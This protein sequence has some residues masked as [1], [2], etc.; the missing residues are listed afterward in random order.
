MAAGGMSR[1]NQLR[2]WDSQREHAAAIGGAVFPTVIFHPIASK[3][4]TTSLTT[5]GQHRAALHL[6]GR[7]VE[8]TLLRG[9][10]DW[11][12]HATSWSRCL[13]SNT[14][15][16]PHGGSPAA[17]WSLCASVPERN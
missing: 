15:T 2:Q 3:W 8:A 10:P 17:D 7:L 14:M 9:S 11:L 4:A 12:P 16:N 6:R 1:S 5:H 13:A